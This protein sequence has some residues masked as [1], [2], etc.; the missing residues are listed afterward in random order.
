M[1][2]L[3]Y[4]KARIRMCRTMVL[5]EGGCVAC[6]LYD[7]LRNR[8]WLAASAITNPDIDTI[9]THVDSVIEWAQGHPVKTRQREMLKMFPD[10]KIH[11]GVIDF[12]PKGFLP[13]EAGKAYC[14]KYGNCN[15][16]R[17]DYWFTEVPE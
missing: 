5:K 17:K 14:E 15:E 7:G 11:N 3:E 4:E 6:P 16:C 9:E 1:D 12:C 13:E 8:C 2:A 10:A